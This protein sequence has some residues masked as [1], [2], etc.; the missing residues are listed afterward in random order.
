M[1]VKA[2]VFDFGGVLIDWNP[3]YL[4]RKVFRDE[5]EMEYF[6]NNICTPEWNWRMDKDKTF[7]E[8]VAE[9]KAIHP[10]YAREIEM[11]DTRWEEMRGKVFEDSV[12]ILKEVAAR[13]PVY[14]LTNW[15]TEKFAVTRPKFDFF[16]IFKGIVVSGHEREAKPEEP[17]FHIL[18]E[19][20]GLA[21]ETTLFI[22]DSLP[23]IETAKRLGFQTIHFKS[24]PQLRKALEEK[25]ILPQ[26]GSEEGE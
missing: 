15:S 8:S 26:S 24:A 10:E 17:I 1:A 6:L 13:F 18:L 16:N 7:A 11:Y 4:Y 19:R 2:V 9:L 23:N 20:Y 21:A 14:G 12:E 3:R 5:A 25:G 22:D